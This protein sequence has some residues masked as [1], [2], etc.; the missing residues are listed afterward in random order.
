MSPP[1]PFELSVDQSVLDLLPFPIT[2]ISADM[3]VSLQASFTAAD[4]DGL[5]LGPEAVAAAFAAAMR[6]SLQDPWITPDTT[7]SL[8]WLLYVCNI[9]GP[10]V[11]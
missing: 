6:R 7:V 4:V 1:P 5:R 2:D 9:A 8:M 10:M 11:A 3:L